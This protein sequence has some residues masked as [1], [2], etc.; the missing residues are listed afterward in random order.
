MKKIYK[1]PLTVV[2]KIKSEKMICS[3]PEGFAKSIGTT[4]KNGSAALDKDYD[5][6]DAFDDL[7]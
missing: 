3:S 4:G 6:E 7:W 1:A 5:D 2:V